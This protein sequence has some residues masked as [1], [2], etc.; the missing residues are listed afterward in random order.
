MEGPF[1]LK[2]HIALV[3]GASRGIGAAVAE[4]LAKAGAIVVGTSTTDSGADMI[5]NRMSKNSLSGRG[6]ILDVTDRESINRL[7]N[8]IAINEGPVSLLVNNAGIAQDNLLMRMQDDQW[9]E[10]IEANLGGV[11]NLSRACLKGMLKVPNG[12]IIN[13]AS[14]IG[15]MGNAGQVNYAASKAG[16]IGFTKALAREVGSRG[17]TVNSIAPGFI[18]TDMT[19]GISEQLRERLLE[20]IPLNRFGDVHEIASAVRFL[21]SPESSYITG[22]TLHINGGMYMI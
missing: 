17:V 4:T 12:R 18:K 9:D 19:D 5:S 3:S 21:A 7:I 16:I 13:I 8:D 1:S 10:V 14:V 2:G 22:E 11:F 15:V 6:A 20:Q